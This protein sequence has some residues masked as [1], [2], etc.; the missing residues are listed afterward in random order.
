MCVCVCVSAC[1][2]V[3]GGRKC[4]YTYLFLESI[5]SF[6]GHL[7]R[8]QPEAFEAHRCHQVGFEVC[9]QVTH[10]DPVVG[11]LGSSHTGHDGAE[12]EVH[13]VGVAPMCE[14]VCMCV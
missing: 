4:T 3:E 1:A 9:L 5:F 2:N 6:V 10:G 12:L 7:L 13:D 8:C 14:Y 11:A